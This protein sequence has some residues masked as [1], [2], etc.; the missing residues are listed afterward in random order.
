MT[1]SFLLDTGPLVALLNRRDRHHEW[2]KSLIDER[3]PPSFT[4]EA[5]L[6]EACF[7]LRTLPAGIDAILSIL[8]QGLVQTPFRLATEAAAVR[9][10]MARYANVPMSLADACLVRMSEIH[11]DVPVVTFDQDFDVYRRSGRRA[12]PTLMPGE[13]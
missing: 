8:E 13:R 11:V 4:C 12:I 1:P 3:R 10:L 7:L 6:S 5:V 2:A 9:R